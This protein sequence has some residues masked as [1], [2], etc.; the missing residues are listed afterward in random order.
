[1][2]GLFRRNKAKSRLIGVRFYGVPIELE[3][4]SLGEPELDG[5]LVELIEEMLTDN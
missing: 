4:E 3:I 1:M 2:F 5:I